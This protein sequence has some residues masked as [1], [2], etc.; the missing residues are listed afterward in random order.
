VK[1]YLAFPYNSAKIKRADNIKGAADFKG[2]A[3]FDLTDRV[4]QEG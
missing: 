1:Q 2:T 3:T 4:R